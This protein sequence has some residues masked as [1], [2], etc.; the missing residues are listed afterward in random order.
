MKLERRKWI[1]LPDLE[2]LMKKRGSAPSLDVLVDAILEG[3]VR[4][5]AL[6]AEYQAYQMMAVLG[7]SPNNPILQHLSTSGNARCSISSLNGGDIDDQHQREP[8]DISFDISHD[9]LFFGAG[10]STII[11]AGRAASYE[12]E[13]VKIKPSSWRDGLVNIDAGT[14]TFADLPTATIVHCYGVRVAAEDLKRLWPRGGGTPGAPRRYAELEGSTRQLA[15]EGSNLIK[16]RT[17]E[18]P[19]VA[20]VGRY[21][22][23]EL[24]AQ[25]RLEDGPAVKWFEKRIKPVLEKLEMRRPGPK[26]R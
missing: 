11:C 1:P 10:N 21:V 26:S 6:E 7:N 20:A 5:M 22:M 15:I 13:K 16:R 12:K 17:G 25:G 8:N 14:I 3:E 9:N 4:T 19:S 18:T 2:P 23:G 24:S